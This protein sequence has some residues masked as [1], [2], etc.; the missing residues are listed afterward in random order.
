MRSLFVFFSYKIKIINIILL[1]MII[2][3]WPGIF[4]TFGLYQVRTTVKFSED[5]VNIWK[6]VGIGAMLIAAGSYFFD[7]Q[8]VTI[9]VLVAFWISCS[10]TTFLLRFLIRKILFQVRKHGRNLR[11]VV[12][13]GNGKRGQALASTLMKKK[14][15]GYKFV[16]FVDDNIDSSDSNGGHEVSC[17]L[18]ELAEFLGNHVVDEVFINLPV[19]SHYSH[20]SEVITACEQQ[21]ILVHIPLNFFTGGIS[22]IKSVLLDGIPFVVHYTGR[23]LDLRAMFL[24]RTMDIILSIIFIILFLP[25]SIAIVLL[26]KFTSDKGSIFFIQD[27]VGHNKRMFTL[28]KFRTMVKDAEAMQPEFEHLNEVD[29]PIFK[30][31]DDPRITKIGKFLRNTSLDELPQLFNVLKGDMSLVGPRPLPIR[32]VNLFDAQWPKRRFSVRPGMTGLWQINGRN[33]A[34]FDELIK[35]DLKYIDNWSPWLDM[36]IMFKTVPAVMGG[37][38]AM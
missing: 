2:V 33:Q 32:D 8:N 15:L 7:R 24:K 37:R 16:G 22:K 13:I 10:L 11:H 25:S 28:I 29:G 21:G 23:E 26:I 35:Y 30:I 27:R 1:G 3:I 18:D 9:N 17:K 36:N 14:E 31:K 19:K 4:S 6:A 38:G 34:E 12:V 20:I 5:F